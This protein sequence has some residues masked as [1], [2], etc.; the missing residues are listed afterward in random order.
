MLR[1]FE[2]KDLDQV[3]DIWLTG[4]LQAHPFVEESYWRGQADRVR[5]LM[6]QAQLLV[7]EE[8]GRVTG[9]L[10]LWGEHIE[11][12]FVSPEHQGRGIGKALLQAAK[13]RC[14]SLTLNVYQNNPR[15]AAFY[16]RVAQYAG[17]EEEQ[18]L[19]DALFKLAGELAVLFV[20]NIALIL[21]VQRLGTVLG[22][23]FL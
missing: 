12:I 14:P 19:S 17:L 1:P 20:L 22:V 7:W 11:G 9:F 13:E 8:A 18:V 4:N 2:D 6:G 21:T 23:P 5:E 3:M 16:R 10:G 15:A